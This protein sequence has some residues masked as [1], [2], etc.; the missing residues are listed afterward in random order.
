[1]ETRALT[2][3]DLP[4]WADLLSACAVA[5]DTG[6]HYAADDLVED[7]SAPGMDPE[8][9]T[10]AV[11]VDGSLAGYAALA[12][13]D[14]EEPVFR[15]TLDAAVHPEHRGRGVG[16]ALLEWAV[17]GARARHRAEGAGRPLNL[18]T[19]LPDT[20]RRG[21]R[22]LRRHG[23]GPVRWFAELSLELSGPRPDPAG[24]PPGLELRAYRDADEEPLRRLRN[25]AFAAH[26]GAG[27][28]SAEEW[29]HYKTRSRVFRPELTWVALD[30]AI[31]VG[32]ALTQYYAADTAAT[33]VKD[34][35]IDTVGTAATHRRRG[36]ASAL[37]NRVIG[38]AA[39][40]GFD[41]VSLGVDSASPTGAD[42]LY[43]SLG[44]RPVRTS[45]TYDLGA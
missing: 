43:R 42:T 35:W 36:I 39:E 37:I 40:S 18:R 13:R 11:L 23:F 9:D 14:T 22:L 7:L 45:V 41:T 5:D 24:D 12:V 32:L 19:D 20:D 28:L 31:P 27:L 4:A 1:M 33:G 15:V 38:T 34:A 21:E 3:T 30:G 26:F 8:R 16:T 25:A 17:R 44:F 2:E 6:E 10:L 29:R